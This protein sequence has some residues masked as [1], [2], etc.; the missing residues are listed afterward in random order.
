MPVQI[1]VLSSADVPRYKAL[2]LHAYEHAADAF[3]STADERAREPDAWWAKRIAAADGLTMAF[4]ALDGGSLVGSVAL[5]FSAK[6]KTRHSALVVG[7]VVLPAWRGQGIAR[8]LL[9]AAVDHCMARGG[10]RVLRLEA[11]EGNMPAIALYRQFGFMQWG[12][13]PLALRTPDGFKA[14]VH[15]WLEL[16]PPSV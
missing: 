1:A 7:M 16:S 2:M 3:T 9:Q 5:E 13:E 6:P 10:V 12:L 15:M 14:K 4:G 8:R 11:T